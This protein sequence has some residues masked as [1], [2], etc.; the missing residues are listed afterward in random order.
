QTPVSGGHRI[1]AVKGFGGP[2]RMGKRQRQWRRRFAASE[3]VGNTSQGGVSSHE[4]CKQ[5]RRD[6]RAA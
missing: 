3:M 5:W 1:A 6:G 2:Q 4:G